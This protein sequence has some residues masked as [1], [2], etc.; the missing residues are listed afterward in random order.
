MCNL[1]GGKS[2]AAVA[3][4]KRAE[5][6]HQAEQILRQRW[7]AGEEIPVGDP[8]GALARL[9]GE[10]V[11]FKDYLRGEVVALEGVLSYWTE[12]TFDDGSEIRTAAVENVRATVAAYERS[13]DRAAK[14]LANIVKL[15]LAG[16]MLE[17]NQAKAELMTTTIR[18]ALATVDM[19][20]EIRRATQEAIADAITG[21]STTARPRELT[22]G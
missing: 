10:V 12:T 8:L 19:P 20:A 11:A 2:P 16:R 1:H 5:I 13:L 21:L 14:I 17:V 7:A 4:L 9:A 3:M 15:D 22:A 18:E 6:E